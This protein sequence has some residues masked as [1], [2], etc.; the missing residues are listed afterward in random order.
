MRS[1]FLSCALLAMFVGYLCF[2]GGQIIECRAKNTDPVL[3]L[4]GI[5]CVKGVK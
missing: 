2:I 1:L 4:M 5:V 3:G